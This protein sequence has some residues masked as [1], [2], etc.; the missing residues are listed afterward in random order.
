MLCCLTHGI[1]VDITG[2][3]PVE[4]SEKKQLLINKKMES[5]HSRSRSQ[6]GT[7][8]TSI[9][10]SPLAPNHSRLTQ[11]FNISGDVF[12]VTKASKHTSIIQNWLAYD[13]IV[14]HYVYDNS[15]FYV[16]SICT[17]LQCKLHTHLIG[18][19]W[20]DETWNYCERMSFGL[21]ESALFRI[22]FITK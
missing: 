19:L 13:D 6:T 1:Y 22:H 21:M 10:F 5:W 4:P 7:A 14:T 8:Y 11:E 18:Y 20:E 17:A 15:S 3:F 2:S 9:T 12:C 16:K